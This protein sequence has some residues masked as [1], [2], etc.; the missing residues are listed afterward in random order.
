MPNVLLASVSIQ[1]G[2][3]NVAATGRR[4]APRLAQARQDNRELGYA[5]DYIEI[6]W[7]EQQ[8]ERIMAL[9][10]VV[11]VFVIPSKPVRS[12]IHRRSGASLIDP[13]VAV[14]EFR[15]ARASKTVVIFNDPPH[16][17]EDG[18]LLRFVGSVPRCGKHVLQNNVLR[19]PTFGLSSRGNDDIA[20]STFQRKMGL[21][22]RCADFDA[23]EPTHIASRQIS[24]INYGDVPDQFVPLIK[25]M[26]AARGYSDVGTL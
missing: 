24:S 19:R 23:D 14:A 8:A 16:I 20:R 7:S 11:T 26:D 21:V 2:E 4:F 15:G 18:I 17:H 9:I 6:H 10:G 22:A 25:Q 3:C 1:S 12:F 13:I 5:D